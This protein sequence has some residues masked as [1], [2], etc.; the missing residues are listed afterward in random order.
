MHLPRMKRIDDGRPLPTCTRDG[1]P[2]VRGALR[3]PSSRQFTRPREEIGSAERSDDPLR[4]HHSFFV[5]PR[6]LLVIGQMTDAHRA[7]S[8]VGN[9]SYRGGVLVAGSV[10]VRGE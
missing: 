5:P 8:V 2:V 3:K 1:D 7:N 6:S 9:D 10:A 4:I